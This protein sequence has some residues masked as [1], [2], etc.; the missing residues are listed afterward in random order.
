MTQ[1]ANYSPSGESPEREAAKSMAAEP[2]RR[3]CETYWSGL[4]INLTSGVIYNIIELLKGIPNTSGDD[5]NNSPF[6]ST[7]ENKVK[8]YNESKS[9]W[10]KVSLHGLHTGG[11]T[12]AG[13]ECGFSLSTPD[14]FTAGRVVAVPEDVYSFTNLISVDRFGFAATQGFAISISPAARN[15]TLDSVKLI[16]EQ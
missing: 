12:S 9:T 13:M 7:A 15:Y 16:V 10:V 14:V 6:I 5:I 2:E 4:S 1:F 11:G 8:L 3:K